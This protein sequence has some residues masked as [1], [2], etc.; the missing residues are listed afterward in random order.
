M[1]PN[2]ASRLLGDGAHPLEDK[3]VDEV[4]QLFGRH[5]AVIFEPFLHDARR[6]DRDKAQEDFIYFRITRFSQ[7]PA[8]ERSF[9]CVTGFSTMSCNSAS[10]IALF[11]RRTRLSTAFSAILTPTVRIRT[12]RLNLANTN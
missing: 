3:L 6:S 2:W 12:L 9:T 11:V 7:V 1:A 5:P 8:G 4:A 10:R